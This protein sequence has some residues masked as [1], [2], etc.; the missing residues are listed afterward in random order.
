MKKII[1]LLFSLFLIFV[2]GCEKRE[3]GILDYQKKNIEAECLINEKY[4]VILKK[5]E[6]KITLTV[7]EPKEIA[8]ISFETSE[9]G[10]LAKSAET[11]IQLEKGKMRGIEALLG[12]FS[13]SEECMKKADKSGQSSILT[14][15][16]ES[17][18]YVITVG[19]N[20]LPKKVKITSEEFEY[21]VDI[22]AIKIS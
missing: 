12:I 16:N 20:S 5:E 4:R 22:Y 11:K 19:E 6:E 3:Y 8:D 9:N 7:K 17:C 14:F 15:E 1:A 18:I 2:A 13:Q 21:D 10:V